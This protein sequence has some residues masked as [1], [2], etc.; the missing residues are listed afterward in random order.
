MLAGVSA[1]EEKSESPHRAG[2]DVREKQYRDMEVVDAFDGK[3]DGQSGITVGYEGLLEVD[4]DKITST[5][6]STTG[7][8]TERTPRKRPSRNCE[9]VPSDKRSRPFEKI[10]SSS[11]VPP[12]KARSS[13]SSRRRCS[14]SNSTP[15]S[16]MS[17]RVM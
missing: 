2:E 9:A 17:S 13:T 4:P 8:G 12:I 11:V 16:S 5:L 7:T 3:Y 15:T 14:A 1:W 6:P 10:T